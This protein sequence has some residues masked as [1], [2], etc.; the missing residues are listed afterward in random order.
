METLTPMPRWS[1]RILS[2]VV[3]LFLLADAL[4]KLLQVGPI[5]EGT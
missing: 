4:G 2:G 3:V 1:G 5:M